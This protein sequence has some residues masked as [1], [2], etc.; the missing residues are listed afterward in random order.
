[1]NPHLISGGRHTDARGS[2]SFVNGF[3][4]KGVDRFYWIQAGEPNL[5]RG[6]VGHQR[7]HKWF[8]VLRGE[9]LL[10]VVALE[11]WFSHEPDKGRADTERSAGILPALDIGAQKAGHRPVLRP[12]SVDIRDDSFRNRPVTR[13]VLTAA[14]PQVL[15]VPP[16]HATGSVQ[17]TPEAILMIFSSGKIEDVHSDDFRFPVDY[18]P[19]LPETKS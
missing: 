12:P 18:W 13:Y 19:I 7:E 16:D 15:H 8:S 4:F 6:W 11:D 5:P 9:V 2:V 14:N 3:D 1:M 10:A 17:L